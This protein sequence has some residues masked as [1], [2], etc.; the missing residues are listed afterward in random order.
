MF[1]DERTILDIVICVAL[2]V[3]FIWGGVKVY[4]LLNSAENETYT[5][6]VHVAAIKTKNDIE[7]HIYLRAGSVKEESYYYCYKV[8]DDGSKELYKIKM[9]TTKVYET[10]KQNDQPYVEEIRDGL[11]F[12]KENKLYVP[13]NTIKEEYD[14][15]LP[16]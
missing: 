13:Q 6:V 4:K 8:N 5:N 10:L 3:T 11:G 1:F 12:L 16:E 2:C 9:D 7:G 15:S 14:L